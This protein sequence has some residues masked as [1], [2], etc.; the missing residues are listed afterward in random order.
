M[1]LGIDTRYQFTVMELKRET[2][3]LKALKQL[4]DY[5]EWVS[6]NLSKGDAYLIQPTLVAYDFDKSVMELA[7][8][9]HLQLY[10]TYKPVKLIQYRYDPAV[11]LELQDILQPDAVQTTVIDP[12]RVE[13]VT[14]RMQAKPKRL[15]KPSASPRKRKSVS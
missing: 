10:A 9:E 11:G 7:Q 1:Y 6:D 14:K 15:T 12:K 3:D 4:L 2:A 8:S 5:C 13:T